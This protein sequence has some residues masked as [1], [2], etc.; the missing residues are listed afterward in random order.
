MRNHDKKIV[1]CV[2]MFNLFEETLFSLS[3]CYPFQKISQEIYI[4][5]SPSAVVSS[6]HL[7][8]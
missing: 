7:N 4:T 5:L 6:R 1:H 8:R 3:L 2:V